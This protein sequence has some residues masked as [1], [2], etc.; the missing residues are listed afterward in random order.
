MG[1]LKGVAKIVKFA[2]CL[3]FAI[4]QYLCKGEKRGQTQN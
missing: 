3:N 1:F 2:Y 4:D